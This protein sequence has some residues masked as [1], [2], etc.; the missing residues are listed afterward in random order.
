MVELVPLLGVLATAYGFVLVSAR[1]FRTGILMH[2][3]K[4]TVRELLAGSAMTEATT[5]P[6]APR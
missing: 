6:N 2:G 3:K 5:Q 1:I 4:I